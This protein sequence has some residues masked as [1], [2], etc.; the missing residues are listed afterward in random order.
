MHQSINHSGVQ[1][2]M[3]HL[4]RI[5]VSSVHA[6]TNSGH[7]VGDSKRILM[8]YYALDDHKSCEGTL[9]KYWDTLLTCVLGIYV[10]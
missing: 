7:F 6:K 4:I 5:F 2:K 10:R 8:S 9:Y 3:L 1:T